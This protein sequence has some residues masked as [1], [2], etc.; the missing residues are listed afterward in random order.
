MTCTP[1]R[2][3]L[4]GILTTMLLQS[5]SLTSVTVVG[6]VNARLISLNQA[7]AI[8]I[9]AN[10]G[11]TITGQLLSFEL[12]GLALPI[13]V[14]GFILSLFPLSSVSKFGSSLRSFGI[15][16]LGFSFMVD[17]FSPLKPDKI[18]LVIDF[19]DNPLNLIGL[20]FAWSALLQS[21]SAV[22]GTAMAMLENEVIK[23]PAAVALT[24]GADVGTS[25][26]A[27]IASIKTIGAAKKTAWGHFFFNLFS[28]LL[29]L[30]FWNAFICLVQLTSIDLTR[31]LANAH[32]IYNLFGAL[33]FLPL[34]PIWVYLLDHFFDKSMKNQ[35][36]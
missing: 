19:Q 22:I 18:P 31:Q 33:I 26:T 10:V 36:F 13:I 15:L 14:V 32:T 17:A 20:G 27:L 21:S 11:T 4:T 30:P 2:G 8:I 6:M 9:G 1:W 3:L 35:S 28:A 34:I 23:F 24:I 5:S 12:H 25:I 16:L 7:L 29:L